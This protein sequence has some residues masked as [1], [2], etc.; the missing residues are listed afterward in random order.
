MP[1][2]VDK[3]RERIQKVNQL[4]LFGMYQ[5]LESGLALRGWPPGKALEYLILR[6]FELASAEVTYPYSVSDG[7]I[8]LEQ[9]D[10]AIWTSRLYTLVESK[11]YEG[12][13]NFEPI[14]KIRNQLSRRPSSTMACVF[15]MNGFT[16]AALVLTQY[17]SPLNVL[18]WEK[19][20]IRILLEDATLSPT[21]P[22]DALHTKYKFAVEHGMP[23]YNIREGY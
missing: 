1:A 16:Q 22:I 15:S 17:S 18:L 6:C 19:Q 20:E 3:Y 14:A 10:G 2:T 11:H 12:A 13:V 9:I 4:Q 21:R 23:D 8:T 7:N 5:D